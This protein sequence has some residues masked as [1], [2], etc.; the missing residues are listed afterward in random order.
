[1]SGIIAVSCGDSTIAIGAL[2]EVWNLETVLR[3]RLFRADAWLHAARH[4]HRYDEQDE[5]E[6]DK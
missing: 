2:N 1:M 4:D 3:S 5:G 6:C